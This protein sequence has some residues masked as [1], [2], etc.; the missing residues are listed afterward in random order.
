MQSQQ[1]QPD[2]LS[3]GAIHLPA[4]G[5]GLSMELDR[6]CHRHPV[7]PLTAQSAGEPD[8]ATTAHQLD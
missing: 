5:Q 4:C 7:R 8:V 2:G 6:V 1:Q 3:N